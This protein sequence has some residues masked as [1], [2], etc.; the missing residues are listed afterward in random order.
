[1][2]FYLV[3]ICRMLGGT[4]VLMLNVALD[5]RFPVSK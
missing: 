1:M 3:S 4:N 5:Q 2:L